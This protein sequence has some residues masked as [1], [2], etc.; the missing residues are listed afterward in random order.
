MIDTTNG[1]VSV[2]DRILSGATGEA[3]FT[4]AEQFG[5]RGPRYHSYRIQGEVLGRPAVVIVTFDDGS[6]QSARIVMVE[7]TATGVSD[8]GRDEAERLRERHDSLLF[9]ALGEGP[10]EYPWGRVTSVVS[11]QNWEASIS[12][13]WDEQ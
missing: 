4:E 9:D 1:V 12:V 5:Y 7:E 13:E 11:Q 8:W 3:E 10:Y 6:M 2:G